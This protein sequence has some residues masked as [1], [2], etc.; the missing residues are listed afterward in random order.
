MT[1]ATKTKEYVRPMKWTWWLSH[2]AYTKF[3]IREL[4]AVFI[5]AYC[6]FLLVLQYRAAHAID[7]MEVFQSFLENTLRTPLSIVLHA[8]ALLFALVNTISFLHLTP[9]VLVAYRGEERV[10]DGVIVGVHYLLFFLVSLGL[11]LIPVLL[12]MEPWHG[13]IQ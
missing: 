13:E 12:A 3:M 1:G 4:S 11:I 2:P 8:I 7:E 5:A 9:R 6:V 10:P